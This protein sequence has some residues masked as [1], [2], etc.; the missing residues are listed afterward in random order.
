M[1]DSGGRVS[2]GVIYLIVVAAISPS[3]VQVKSTKRIDGIIIN[4]YYI[5]VQ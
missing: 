5:C 4:A 2:C 3:Y 1:R